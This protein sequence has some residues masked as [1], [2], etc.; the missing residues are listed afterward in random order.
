MQGR[1]V[2]AGRVEAPARVYVPEKAALLRDVPEEETL[3]QQI[4]T[5]SGIVET[6]QAQLELFKL[7]FKFEPSEALADSIEKNKFRMIT[8]GTIVGQVRS[9]IEEDGGGVEQALVSLIRDHLQIQRLVDSDK[10]K[11]SV[12]SIV[13]IMEKILGSYISQNGAPDVGNRIYITASLSLDDLP[14]LAYQPVAGLAV[15]GEVEENFGD[16]LARILRIP[17]VCGLDG[18]LDEVNDDDPVVLDG[19]EGVFERV[20]TAS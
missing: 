11:G 20:S 5:L 8:K 2:T 12:G 4:Q 3:E 6:Y 9:V 17:T 19:D 7:E 18:V 10:M 15:Q 16:A 1:S 13:G 14:A